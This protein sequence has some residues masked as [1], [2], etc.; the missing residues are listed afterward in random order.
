MSKFGY[1][2]YG[3]YRGRTLDEIITAKRIQLKADFERVAYELIDIIG[4]DE[5]QALV[6]TWDDDITYSQMTVLVNRELDRYECDCNPRYEPCAGCQRR[7][8]AIRKWRNDDEYD[9]ASEP[10]ITGDQEPEQA[11]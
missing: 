7:Y 6:D 5:W 10:V 1:G 11:W 2:N 8:E 3:G 9:P 4:D